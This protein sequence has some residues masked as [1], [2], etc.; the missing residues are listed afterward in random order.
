LPGQVVTIRGKHLGDAQ[1][2]PLVHIGG[3]PCDDVRVIVPEY[4]L[5]CTLPTLPQ[6]PSLPPS[7]ASS[8]EGGYGGSGRSENRLSRDSER[9]QWFGSGS[10]SSGAGG[11]GARFGDGGDAAGYSGSGAP[12]G[13]EGSGLWGA[14]PGTTLG[15]PWS[16]FGAPP[17]PPAWDKS[18]H[19]VGVEGPGSRRRLRDVAVEVTHGEVP[20]VASAAGLLSYQVH[21]YARPFYLL[22]YHAFVFSCSN[23]HTFFFKIFNEFLPNLVI[24]TNSTTF[25][26]I[27]YSFLIL[28]TLNYISRSHSLRCPRL[29]P[30]CLPSAT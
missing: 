17:G 12:S 8:V 27:F 9:G 25:V 4:E 26:Y 30:S 20:Q 3:V 18:T 19:G 23:R 24:G 16:R 10:S 28:F 14:S 7:D 6:S 11:W 13:G 22:W 29:R 2:Q 15:G 5:Q 21:L 1:S